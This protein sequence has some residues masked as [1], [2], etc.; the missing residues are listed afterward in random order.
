MISSIVFG[1]T[2]SLLN[3]VLGS[4]HPAHFVI[5]NMSQIILGLAGLSANVIMTLSYLVP[6][7]LIHHSFYAS[8]NN[9]LRR[10]TR[11]ESVFIHCQGSSYASSTDVLKT[12][13]AELNRIEESSPY[14]P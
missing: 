2:S 9:E 11:A 6:R 4:I 10:L 13:A 12:C 8:K 1:S 5:V 14:V 3:V 7:F